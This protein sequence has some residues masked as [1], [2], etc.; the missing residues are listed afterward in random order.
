LWR[1]SSPRP[2]R[3]RKSK[4]QLEKERRKKVESFLR[5]GVIKSP[6][7]AD[8]ML[9]VPREEFVPPEYRDHSYRE[10]PL[11]LPALE[12]T[13]SSPRSYAIF[14][15]ALELSRGDRL[16]EIGTGSG[17]G[18]ALAREIVG[19]EGLVISLEIDRSAFSYARSNLSRLGYGDII[20]IRGDG[21]LGYEPEAPYDK[22]S[23]TAAVP[24]MP[25]PLLEQ[26]SEDGLAVAPVGSDDSQRIQL[27]R[28]DSTAKTIAGSASF[29]PMIRSRAARE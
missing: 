25:Q 15:E 20:L 23:V 4:A 9:K 1:W 26:L 5:E 29:V 3:P 6:L 24:R 21:Y 22:I 28:K 2:S 17:Y 8:A 18:A 12:A 7:L 10:I 14:Y 13:V 16:L 27:I 11:P 19:K